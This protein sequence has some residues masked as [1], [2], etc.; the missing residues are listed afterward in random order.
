MIRRHWGN[1]CRRT[2]AAPAN[3]LVPLSALQVG[4]RA[5]VAEVLC[6]HGLMCRMTSLGFTPGVE[7]T[8]V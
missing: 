8:V 1:R 4:E 5:E 7:V 3:G 6:G 2:F